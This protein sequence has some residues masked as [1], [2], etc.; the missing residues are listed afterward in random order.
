MVSP[1]REASNGILG[2]DQ[3]FRQSGELRP[4]EFPLGIK[5]IDE[6]HDPGLFFRREAFD[7]VNDLRRSHS[8]RLIR[9]PK[10]IKS[11]LANR[12]PFRVNGEAN[13]RR[14]GKG[15]SGKLRRG[16]GG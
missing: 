10:S 12:L 1:T 7:F 14:K 9:V 15:E 13:E 4:A 3:T 11:C 8:G 6:A 5:L 16:R 2:I